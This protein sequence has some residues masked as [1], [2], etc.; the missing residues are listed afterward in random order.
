MASNIFKEDFLRTLF[1]TTAIFSNGLIDPYHIVS[2][3]AAGQA[4]EAT[5]ASIGTTVI[6]IRVI[7][8]SLRLETIRIFTKFHAGSTSA[9]Y[10]PCRFVGR[11]ASENDGHRHL[12]PHFRMHGHH[13]HLF[14]PTSKS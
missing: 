13:T 4:E 10:S 14:Q 9:P 1:R 5:K 3:P 8:L 12:K 11:L 6:H 7:F 2:D